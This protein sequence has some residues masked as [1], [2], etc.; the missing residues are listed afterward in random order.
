[1]YIIILLKKCM[2]HLPS[3][4]EYCVDSG[5]LL[6]FY[7]A[8]TSL[9][10][11]IMIMSFY[12]IFI[13]KKNKLFIYLT[14]Q[15]DIDACQAN[16]QVFW[17]FTCNKLTDFCGHFNLSNFHEPKD[18]MVPYLNK[19]EVS[20]QFYFNKPHSILELQKMCVCFKTNK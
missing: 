20:L 2:F 9:I 3:Y 4:L 11:P 12:F 6:M 5:N 13:L 14:F 15:P 7:R 17:N 1:M 8:D 10:K 16:Q 18:S 19:L